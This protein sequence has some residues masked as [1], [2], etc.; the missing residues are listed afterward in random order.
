M[1]RDGGHAVAVDTLNA[2]DAQVDVLA[3]LGN[4]A[5]CELIGGLAFRELHRASDEIF[6][7]RH[8]NHN[9]RVSGK[10]ERLAGRFGDA[11]KR[12]AP[13][14]REC[15]IHAANEAKTLDT[16]QIS[17]NRRVAFFHD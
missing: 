13:D 12:G 16:G 11:G 3:D 8:L 14:G 2:D 15:A 6:T 17:V 10:G 1:N 9:F 4:V 5:A 7:R